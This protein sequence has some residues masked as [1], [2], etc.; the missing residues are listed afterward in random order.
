[1]TTG[2]NTARHNGAMTPTIASLVYYVS[3]GTPG[4]EFTSQPRAATVTEVDPGDPDRVG[5]CVMNPTGLFFHSL[6][7]GGCRY[8]EGAPNGSGGVDYPGGTW[9]WPPRV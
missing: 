4:G 8:D 7:A 2:V 5:L 3:Y 6:A 1:M 9:H